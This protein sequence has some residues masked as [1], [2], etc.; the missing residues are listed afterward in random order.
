MDLNRFRSLIEQEQKRGYGHVKP[1]SPSDSVP[2]PFICGTRRSNARNRTR[3]RPY[4]PF[5]P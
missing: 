1:V 3:S 4:A 2:A 5:Y